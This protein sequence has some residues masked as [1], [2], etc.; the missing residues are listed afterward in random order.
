M[1]S[2]ATEYWDCPECDATLANCQGLL[3][4]IDCGW[5]PQRGSDFE[6]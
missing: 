6:R 3:N 2:D 5:V 1:A 4:C